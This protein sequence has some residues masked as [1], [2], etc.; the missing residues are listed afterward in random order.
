MCLGLCWT[1][2]NAAGTLDG[3]VALTLIPNTWA[4]GNNYSASMNLN[5][6]NSGSEDWPPGTYNLTITN[7]NM[8]DM[9]QTWG[10]DFTSAAHGTA[11]G[12]ITV[13]DSV[14]PSA[15]VNI[16]AVVAGSSPQNFYPTEITL[17][18]GKCKLQ[19]DPNTLTTGR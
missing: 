10:W 11:S 9:K 19:Q 13:K 14:A 2:S 1:S 15:Q 6:D 18:G 16:G 17:D 7:P 8:L 12:T 5:L 4:A 3:C